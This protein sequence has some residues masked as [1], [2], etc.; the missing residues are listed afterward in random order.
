M[1]SSTAASNV[2]H[3]WGTRRCD[4]SV[5]KMAPSAATTTASA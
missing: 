4:A 3:T 5:T 2:P 1:M